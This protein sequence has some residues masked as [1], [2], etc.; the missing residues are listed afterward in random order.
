MSRDRFLAIMWSL[1]LCASPETDEQNQTKKGTDQYD[2]LIKIKPFYDEL[3]SSCK[4]FYQP[5]R[6]IAIDEKMV[7]AKYMKGKPT[8]WGYKLFGLADSLSGYTWNFFVYVGKRGSV[9]NKGLSYDSVMSLLDLPQLG[10]GY[11]L[12]VDNFYTSPLLFK[13]LTRVKTSACGTIRTNRKGFPDSAGNDMPERAERGTIW[14]IR[15][16]GLLFLKW[17]DGLSLMK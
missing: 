16:Y 15:K 2:P 12:Y 9:S 17:M 8:K 3:L 7:A 10:T 5:N 6:Q 1:H 14:W 13:D 11:R 4:S